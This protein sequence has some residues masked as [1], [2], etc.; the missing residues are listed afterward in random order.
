[1]ADLTEP[2][3]EVG[4]PS[5]AEASGWVG[6]ELDDANGVRVG[7]VHG[8][9]VDSDSGEPRWLIAALERRRLFPGR[10]RS[11]LI[12]IP[13]LDCAA[14]TDRVWTAHAREP[15]RSAP[16]VDPAR[17]LLREHELAISAHYGIGERVG[18]AA[19]VSGRPEGSVTSLPAA[20]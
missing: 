3:P 5:L 8:V 11:V 16:T 6:F 13:V 20:L 4:P 19:E 1:M 2:T 17:P 10:R 7:R 18:R 14:A 15:L 12:A 9:F